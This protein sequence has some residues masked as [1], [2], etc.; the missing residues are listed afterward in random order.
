MSKRLGAIA[1]KSRVLAMFPPGVHMRA[2]I[3][4]ITIEEYWELFANLRA[5]V[6]FAKPEH[7]ES[8]TRFLYAACVRHDRWAVPT[9]I[10][11]PLVQHERFASLVDSL[12]AM[13]GPGSLNTPVF[14]IDRLLSEIYAAYSM[15]PLD[16][17]DGVQLDVFRAAVLTVPVPDHDEKR[18]E[19]EGARARALS[20]LGGLRDRS[21]R[22]TIK[23]KLPYAIHKNP[24]RVSLQWRGLCLQVV[25]SPTFLQ[26]EGFAS[27]Q[28]HSQPV[29]PSRWQAA[30]T[31]VSIEIPALVDLEADRDGLLSFGVGSLPTSKWPFWAVASFEI[32]HD[33]AWMIRLAHSGELQWVP[34]PRDLGDTELYLTTA[35][36]EKFQWKLLGS[37]G[38]L[39]HVFAGSSQE[40]H[41]NIGQLEAPS[42]HLRCRDL[43]KVYLEL[44][45]TNE[46][47]F[48][49]NVAI[50][51]L[52]QYVFKMVAAA[53]P[54]DN[55]D[56]VLS[57][58]AVYWDE[59]ETILTRQFP[60]MKGKVAW[61][62]SDQHVS[63]YR[64]LKYLFRKYEFAC[65]Q[66]DLM[67]NY[68]QISSDRNPLFHGTT[69]RRIDASQIESA[70]ESFDW[71]KRCFVLR[72]SGSS[73]NG[74]PTT[75]QQPTS[76][77]EGARG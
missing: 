8:W 57:S 31:D 25:A 54:G 15:T 36:D 7:N 4:R 14:K 49:V 43:A 39:F 72:D 30:V 62:D 32:I 35:S 24:L 63:I 23:T 42:W 51:S 13:E 73:D 38:A 17:I 19:F 27:M 40:K 22:T 28:P 33:M 21:L 12:D 29:G 16:S 41:V 34:A 1:A 74:P 70:L 61:P 45:E 46:A 26:S 5:S 64:K 37:P 77:P 2:V 3:G 20:I 76:G 67:T 55:L 66:K 52:F 44:G 6:P 18:P 48:W 71:I 69:E 50:E 11:V 56:A 47:L 53:F 75:T 59:A 68:R 10:V 60:G 9:P 58:S 65:S